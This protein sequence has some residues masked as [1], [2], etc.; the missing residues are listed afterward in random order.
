MAFMAAVR[1]GR[2]LRR[3]REGLDLSQVEMARRLGMSAS[4]LNLLEHDQRP[5]TLKLMLKL[6]DT[7]EVDLNAFSQDDDAR[8]ANELIE[9]LADP[10][11]GGRGVGEAEVR[12]LI[13]A[14]P[15]AGQALADVYRAYRTV[16]DQVDDLGEELRWSEIIGSGTHE[17]RTILT[18]IRSFAEILHDNA[19]LDEAQ[20]RSFVD[21]LV[22]ESQ[23]LAAVLDRRS[24]PPQRTGVAEDDA[25]LP[26]AEAVSDYFQANLNYF[27]AL[28][29]AASALRDA[30]RLGEGSDFDRLASY[31]TREHGVVVKVVP[32]R[33]L[34]A[35][36]RQYD[37][38]ERR[39]EVAESLSMARRTF[40]AAQRA[41]L[42]GFER[43]IDAAV[44]SANLPTSAAR[45]LCR[46]A[47]A[48]YV[49]A[50][51]MMPYDPF[52]AAARELR[53]DIDMLSR[54]FGATFEQTCERLTCL[55][56]PDARGIPFHLLVLDIA[57][58]VI[59]RFSGSGIRIARH[60]G[61][62]ARW[63]AHAVFLTPG[64]VRTQLSTTPE[65]GHYVSVARTLDAEISARHGGRPTRAIEL[66]CDLSFAGELIY[67]DDIDVAAPRNTVQIGSTC[68]LC[69]RLDCAE[70]AMPLVS[71]GFAIDENRRGPSRWMTA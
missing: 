53:H 18:S 16:R 67:A 61:V 7:F 11:I 21:I 4:Y 9:I 24:P 47:A 34:G 63:N 52:I 46:T 3:L 6:G 56:R 19:D 36:Q 1:L 8:L 5:L 50:A 57:G 2:K 37:D 54:R 20:R 38:D 42:L 59:R 68:R 28:E 41:A 69:P 44:A 48:D 13:A 60:S 66:G 49:A 14:A 64:Q 70:R 62:C 29:T 45:Q 26:G 51:T 31:L 25:W 55:H 58:N 65:G 33:A 32:D 39:L 40:E 27:P 43:A 23:R 15:A 35:C 10:L 22:K 30:A 12:E 71:G 17:L